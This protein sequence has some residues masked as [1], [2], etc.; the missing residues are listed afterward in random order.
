MKS[1][2]AT[3]LVL[4][5]VLTFAACT[6]KDQSGDYATGNPNSAAGPDTMASSSATSTSTATGTTPTTG[7]AMHDTAGTR[8]EG[9]GLHTT[10]TDANTGSR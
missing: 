10:G 7:D 9:S 8:N 5:T 3:L 4:G 6:R 1:M 2:I